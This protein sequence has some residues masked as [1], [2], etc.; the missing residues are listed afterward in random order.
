[1]SVEIAGGTTAAVDAHVTGRLKFYFAVLSCL[2]G[3]VLG[4]SPETEALPAVAIFFA[5]FGFL[6]VDTLKLFAL[7]P[8]LA[9][10][11]MGLAAAYCVLNFTDMDRPG[12]TQIVAVAELLVMVQGILILQEKNL[13]IFEQLGVFCLLQLVVAAVFSDAIYYGLL[14]VPIGMV[15]LLALGSLS[16]LASLQPSQPAKPK[17]GTTPDQPASPFVRFMPRRDPHDSSGPAAGRPWIGLLGVAP[18]VVLIGLVFFYALPRTMEAPAAGRTGNV[19]VGFSDEV[20]LDQ[21][22][23]LLQ[24]DDVALRVRL[25]DRKTGARYPVFGGLY[26]RGKVLERYASTIEEGRPTASWSAVPLGRLSGSLRL[27]RE[28]NPSRP[29]DR[30][31]FDS[32]V[33]TITCEPMRSPSL[34]SLIPY[35]AVDAAGDLVHEADRWT[36]RRRLPDLEGLH[37]NYPRLK[38]DIGTNGFRNGLQSELTTRLARGDHQWMAAAPGFV[39]NGASGQPGWVRQHGRYIAELL[40]LDRDEIPIASS[41]AESLVEALPADQRTTY[42][43]AKRLE[44]WLK[45]ESGFRYSLRLDAKPIPGMDPIEQFLSVDERGHCQ[46]FASALVMMLRALEIPSRLVVGYKTDEFSELGQTYLARQ[47]HAHAWVEALIDRQQLPQQMIVYGQ[48]ESDQ[49]WLRLD[50]TPFGGPGSPLDPA[51]V[52][53]VRQVFDL[54]QNLWDDYVVEMDRNQQRNTLLSARGMAPMSDSYGAMIGSIR[55][56]LFEL[57][58]DRLWSFSL[59]GRQLFSWPAAIGAVALTLLLAAIFRIPIY[60]WVRRHAGKSV[61]ERAA[62]PSL[63]FYAETLDQLS[64]LGFQRRRAE[65][66]S[67]FTRGASAAVVQRHQVSLAEPLGR[68]TA[69]FYRL[70]FGSEGGDRTIG[71]PVIRRELEQLRYQIDRITHPTNAAEAGPTQEPPTT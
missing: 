52:G 42:L 3:V 37:W 33:A 34:F 62:M 11:A 4:T 36:V 53:G 71:E 60:R 13:R 40:R 1:M 44:Q 55:R 21:F 25:T 51:R 27:P 66:P 26:L 43:Q 48:P 32:V 47:Y 63:P 24:R 6:F 16:I 38:Y 14:L 19:M 58:G 70:R 9:Y 10:A 35:H 22:G 65:T 39:L 54:V 8:P 30:N 28:Y 59:S 2:G 45:F 68:L 64:R 23:Q 56:L 5:V 18:A 12:N 29:T 31:F 46:Y 15:G 20:R 7:P 41:L 69:A 17:A 50:P 67:E 57:R 49:Y 61:E